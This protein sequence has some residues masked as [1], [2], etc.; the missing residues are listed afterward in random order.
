MYSKRD[1]VVATTSSIPRAKRAYSPSQLTQTPTRDGMLYV[2]IGG[3]REEERGSPSKEAEA[4][5]FLVPE[6]VKG[7]SKNVFFACFEVEKHPTHATASCET[8]FPGN[9]AHATAT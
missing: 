1:D 5:C 9:T 7:F 8:R 6:K 2:S 3:F 4:S